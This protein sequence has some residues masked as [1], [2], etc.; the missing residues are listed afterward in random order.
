MQN[1]NHF[2]YKISIISTLS[3]QLQNIHTEKDGSD[4]E[5]R[6]ETGLKEDIY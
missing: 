4:T 6:E 5:I 1:I 3:L 2:N